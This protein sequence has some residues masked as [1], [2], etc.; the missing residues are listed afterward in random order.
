[1]ILRQPDRL[2]I[3]F[4]LIVVTLTVFWQM[5]DHDYILY[6]DP[7]YVFQNPHI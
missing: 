4:L 1:M 6:D 3:S 2:I 5:L 7:G